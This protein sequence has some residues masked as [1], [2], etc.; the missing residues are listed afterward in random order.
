[1][2][3]PTE[4]LKTAPAPPPITA[5]PAMKSARLGV[6][7]QA[8]STTSAMPP[9]ISADAGG[10]RAA[11]RPRR[12]QRLG[13]DARG[14]HREDRHAGQRVRRLVQ[15]ADQ[16]RR[17]QAGE[18]AERA[19]GEERAGGRR[20]ERAARLGRDRHALDAVGGERIGP[21]ARLGRERD[22]DQG[23]RQRDQEHHVGDGQRR[24]D[25]LRPGSRRRAGRGRGRRR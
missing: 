15:R 17:G 22:D 18:Q 21:L 10:Q 13:D 19:E 16:E 25:P 1:M 20:G 8:A 24:A 5:P 3:V 11:R 6:A 9:S 14:E 12:A 7:S 2:T 4:P 23:H